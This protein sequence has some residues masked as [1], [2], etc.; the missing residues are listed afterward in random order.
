MMATMSSI[1]YAKK[2]A[3]SES[4]MQPYVVRK[5]SVRKSKLASETSESVRQKIY[6]TT[7]WPVESS[8]RS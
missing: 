6:R 8:L 5:R 1:L 3:L 2:L 4:L 7:C